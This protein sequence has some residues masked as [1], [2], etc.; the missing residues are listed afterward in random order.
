MYKMGLPRWLTQW[1]IWRQCRRLRVDPWVKKMPWRR[2]RLP[3]PVSLPGEFHGQ[4]S[5]AGYSPGGHKELDTTEWLTHTKSLLRHNI[6]GMN[7]GKSTI[8]H[9][10]ALASGFSFMVKMDN[11]QGPTVQHREFCSM[12]CGSLDGRGVWRRI[13]NMYVHGWVPLLSTWKY[14]NIVNPLYSNIK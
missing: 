13:D 9:V 14:H 10:C 5:L 6:E 11:Q 2:E 1:R 12:L 8:F 3:T 4:R 7:Y